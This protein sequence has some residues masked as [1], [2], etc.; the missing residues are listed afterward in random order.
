M[1]FAGHPMLTED[2]GTQGKNN[3]ELELGYDWTPEASDRNFLF[4]PQLSWGA[5]TTLDLI[6]QPSWIIDYSGVNTERGLGDTNLD[7]KWRFYEGAPWSLAIRA[8][9]SAPTAQDSLGLPH[10]RFLPHAVLI[11]TGDFSPFTLNANLGYGR[12]PDDPS[13]RG[14]L[15]HVSAAVTVQSARQ[16]LLILE[17][18]VDTNPDRTGKTFAAVSQLG[19]SYAVH[20][21]LDVDA[22]F[23]GRIN[24]AGPAQQWL[25]GITF[26][27]G[28]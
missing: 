13:Q 3:F 8:G 1:A 5:S 26:R 12:A 25:V 2:T 27:W 7:A 20:P 16:L 23:R 19:I 22:G 18:S 14:D 4:Q 9:V 15:Y 17:L 11:A 10:D 28:S 24:G 21:G 6:V